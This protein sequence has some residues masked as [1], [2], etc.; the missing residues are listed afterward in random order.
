MHMYSRVVIVLVIVMYCK[1]IILL[2]F[3]EEDPG[4]E[5]RETDLMHEGI[6]PQSKES[7]RSRCPVPSSCAPC[8][9]GREGAPGQVAG[10]RAE[11]PVEVHHHAPGEERRERDRRED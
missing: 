1:R 2:K 11:L 9:L 6:V 4:F 5:E 7:S 3:L 10:G 8:Q